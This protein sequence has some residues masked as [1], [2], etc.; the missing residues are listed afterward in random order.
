MMDFTLNLGSGAQLHVQRMDDSIH[1][2]DR[3]ATQVR[4]L[5]LVEPI[6]MNQG[7]GSYTCSVCYVRQ[8][9]KPKEHG[10]SPNV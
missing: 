9:G 2:R 7:F 8:F 3:P 5:T 10:L 1:F 4:G 6:F